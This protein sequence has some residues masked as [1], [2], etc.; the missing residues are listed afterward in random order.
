MKKMIALLLGVLLCCPLFL[1][2]CDEAAFYIPVDEI[3]WAQDEVEL[4]PGEFFDLDYKVY[5]TN[6]TD[7]S[8]KLIDAERSSFTSNLKWDKANYIDYGIIDNNTIQIL[9]FYN[10]TEFNLSILYQAGGV[11]KTATCHIKKRE[12]PTEI[13][14]E[15]QEYFLSTGQTSKLVV[16]DN[17]GKELDLS[18][19]KVE[20][21][22]S[23]ADRNKVSIVDA[24][25]GMIEG[26]KAG[27]VTMNL[28]ID[29]VQT[30]DS[31]GQTVYK[32][33]TTSCKVNII[34]SYDSVFVYKEIGAIGSEGDI[35]VVSSTGKIYFKFFKNN[36]S[37]NLTNCRFD[38]QVAPD[39]VFT[40]YTTATK[41]SVFEIDILARP[42]QAQYIL[43]TAT[44]SDSGGVS[45]SQMLKIV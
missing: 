36:Y 10:Q 8:L 20:L 30:Q 22:T 7:K 21:T 3:V 14:F 9:N 44:I 41:G 12:T 26:V 27:S 39:C 25:K 37:I 16:V 6:A 42:P 4:M 1:V 24:G 45:Y 23:E 29:F 18:K 19:Y 31:E 28:K 34:S 15:Q 38:V 40:T 5:P 33:L 17:F 11:E 32:T 35:K 2:G 13:K 43:V